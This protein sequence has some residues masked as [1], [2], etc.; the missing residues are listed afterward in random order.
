MEAHDVTIFEQQGSVD[1]SLHLK[2]P[3][4]LDLRSAAEIARRVEEAICARPEVLAVQTHLE[5]L[6]RTLTAR[7]ADDAAELHASRTI[8]ELVRG[9]TGSRPEKIK[10]LATDGG[11]VVFL[12]LRVD[13]Q[14]TLTDAHQ[15]AGELEEELR[16]RL[17]DIADVV[18]HTQT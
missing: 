6:E 13:E 4:D 12:T 1:V 3:A 5:P 17:P 2:F 14:T 8:D 9:R 11:R 7:E 16:L 10:L 15:L 18:I